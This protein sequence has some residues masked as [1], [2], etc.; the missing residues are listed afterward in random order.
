MLV[1]LLSRFLLL[2]S[3]VFPGFAALAQT[4]AIPG[5]D[6][7]AT[8]SGVINSYHA[9]SGSP[10]AGATSISVASISGQ[11]SNTRALQAGDLI[12]IMQMQDSSTPANAGQ[13]EYAQ[14]T[15]VSGGTLSLNRALSYSYA[16]A[17]S[18]S[19]V[20]NWQVIWV[21]QYSSATVSGTVSADRW[22]SDTSTGAATGGVVAMDV[23]G[24]LAVN[25]TISAAG[26]GF[27]GAFSLNGTSNLAGGT[28]TTAN[29][30]FNPAAVYGAQKGEGIAG[31]PPRVFNGTTTPINYTTLLGQGYAL[32]AGGQAAIGN[33]GGGGNDGDPTTGANQY[34]SGGGGGGNAGAGGRGGN[35]WNRDGTTAPLNDP[36]G[37]N[38]GNPAGG[39][40]GNAQ[41]NGA[42][43]LVLGGGGGA[44]TANNATGADSVTTWPPV[45][46]A[47]ANGAAGAV[48]G[49]GSSGGGVV[50]IR[51]GSLTAAGGVIDASGYNAYNRDP[52]AATDAAGGGGAG[53]SVMV[54]AGNGSGAGLT[55]RATGG[56]GGRSNYFNHGPGGG[57]GGGYISTNFAGA[58]TDVSGGQNG[59][60]ACCGGTAGN[61]S[62][63]AYNSTPGS[64]G[65]AVTSGGT[66]TG[67][68]AGAS[69]LPVITASKST[70]TPSI[71]ST[72][73]ASA[74]Y[75]ISL[76]NTAGA[77]ANLFVFDASLPPGWAYTSSPSTTYAY[78]P[79]PP[80]AASAGAE[81]VSAAIPAGLP[82][83]NATSINAGV[84]VALRAS[85]AAPGVV[86]TTGNNSMT[87][88]SFYLPQN[89]S[90]TI[91]FAATIPDTATVGTYHNP[92]GVVYLDPTR[93]NAAAMRMLSPLSQ[94]AGNRSGTAYSANTS[95]ASGATTN[96]A[97][98][99]FNG[100][101]G[102]PTSD[103]VS[104]LP[105][106]S[107]TKAA[108]SA[109]FTVGAA[110]QSY[111]LT[112][113]NNGRPVAN[114]VYAST[115]A[116]D[117][118][119]TA[120]VST[121]LTIT[122]TLPAGMTLT[123]LA[124][125]NPGVWT[126]TPNGSSTTFACS[127]SGAVYPLAASS[128]L[129]TVTATIT[130]SGTACP[131]PATNTAVVTTAA[132]GES[133][134]ANNQ[135]T[136][137]TTIAC[138]ANLTASK[139]NGTNTVVSGS[140]TVYTVTFA[141]LGPAGADGTVVND[142]PSAG[143]SCTVSAC[144]A[145]GGASCPAPAQWPNFLLAG[146]PLAT[147]P[148]GGSVSLL[149]TCNVTATGN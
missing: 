52:I 98:S 142:V 136:L 58:T 78:S 132:I 1:R 92:A 114:Q 16:Q 89:G 149:V 23:A 64:A 121:A 120:M 107:V 3:L 84:A 18:T 123:S 102:G 42:T 27:R 54:L 80:G 62:P 69:C 82:V 130:L 146:M 147:F 31:T 7:P 75:V 106:L 118:S 51:T 6:G 131:G 22:A 74:T 26:S 143:L 57:A 110:G 2:A 138:S 49:S 127:A 86:P 44:G 141:N 128:N 8:P 97:G 111:T 103:N 14:I 124:N 30:V 10:G 126:C 135:S 113:R 12:L 140:T 112:G 116:A 109:T 94:V 108:S 65:S 79:A 60:D 134:V 5:W 45:A 85:G 93:T 73:G 15:A 119:A 63:K 105:D 37:V 46:S 137:T 34:N 13:H 133:T 36:V 43:R 129:V 68:Q 55:I 88:G 87:F 53:G 104:L 33:A 83:N 9:G 32:G 4:C 48:S 67:V 76:S 61:G 29:S 17:M 72:T 71:T 35:S 70:L 77:A 19:S 117:Q 115:Q 144:T 50:L 139:T 81:T 122:D 24:N 47:L 28:A 148:G 91:S 11:R 40:G 95:F 21:P 59:L 100:L 99:N 101:A 41:T 90:I 20:R 25:G 145:S 125:S 96:V 38:G 66:P 56:N 39:L